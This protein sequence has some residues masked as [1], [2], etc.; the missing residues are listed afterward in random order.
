MCL[1][2]ESTLALFSFFFS[3]SPFSP[4]LVRS[5]RHDRRDS[6]AR[7][8]QG[9]MGAT[10]VECVGFL[11]SRD[12]ACRA[13]AV[14]LHDSACATVA[15]I[16]YFI[17]ISAPQQGRCGLAFPPT[18]TFRWN[19]DVA[20]YVLATSYTTQPCGCYKTFLQDDRQSCPPDIV[21][22]STTRQFCHL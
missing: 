13:H 3:L 8:K 22:I 4:Q 14:P 20:S 19:R 9:N 15:C 18:P 2:H 11:K 16:L 6:L 21:G 5:S 17:S 1:P 7:M 10:S 12:I